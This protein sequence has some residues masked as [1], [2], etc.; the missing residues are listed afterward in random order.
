MRTRIIFLLVPLFWIA[1][2][3]NSQ[4]VS[5]D[6]KNKLDYQDGKNYNVHS[7]D[8]INKAEE[9]EL[10]EILGKEAYNKIQEEAAKNSILLDSSIKIGPK[11]TKR[12]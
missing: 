6:Q 8:S 2:N 7:Q 1:C 10:K 4:D 11:I 9:Q 3:E 12:K 5:P